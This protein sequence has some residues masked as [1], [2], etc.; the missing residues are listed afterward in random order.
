MSKVVELS[1][2]GTRVPPIDAAEILDFLQG[3]WRL[4]NDSPLFR[5]RNR[6][7]PW[8]A[9]L[10]KAELSGRAVTIGEICGILN[11]SY[12]T[13]RKIMAGFED[14]GYVRSDRDSSDKRKSIVRLTESGLRE[15]ENFET[16]LA[17][18]LHKLV[19]NANA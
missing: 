19:R 12:P 17:G 5:V 11:V 3:F 15:M 4:Q 16:Q 10:H 9:Y 2:R 7:W 6:D 18:S 8:L 1:D 14:R 13:A